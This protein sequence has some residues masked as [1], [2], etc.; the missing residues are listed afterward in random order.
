MPQ[1]KKQL[2]FS[3]KQCLCASWNIKKLWDKSGTAFILCNDCGLVFTNPLPDIE[4][5]K[6]IYKDYLKDFEYDEEY[7]EMRR[8]G[9][10]LLKNRFYKESKLLSVAGKE[11]L[12]LLDV[13]CGLGFFLKELD[14]VFDTC[15][16]EISSFQVGFARQKLGLN[17]FHG[18]L[19]EAK[20][21][22]EYFDVVT[23][24][25][26][27]E[28][29]HNPLE[30][31][32]EIHRILK[33]GGILALSTPNFKG[34]TSLITKDKWHLCDPEE[35]LY[36]FS[37]K[38]I[39]NILQGNGFQITNIFSDN[40]PNIVKCLRKRKIESAQIWEERKAYFH[41]IESNRVLK[42]GKNII[43]YFLNLIK[44]GDNLRVYAKKA[45]ITDTDKVKNVKKILILDNH[46]IG[47][48]VVSIPL[49]KSVRDNFPDAHISILLRSKLEKDVLEPLNLCDSYYY[50]Q[51]V[52]K[53]FADKK[54][55]LHFILKTLLKL[56]NEKFEMVLNT[57]GINMLLAGLLATV[58][59]AKF[60]VGEA[61]GWKGALF[62]VK[63]FP[64]RIHRVERN[65][66]IGRA[67]GLRS[68]VKNPYLV[69][70]K[71]S[72]IF[73]TKIINEKKLNGKKLVGIHVANPIDQYE[74]CWPAEKYAELIDKISVSFPD[75]TIAIFGSS[76]ERIEV[77]KLHINKISNV[78]DFVGRLEINKTIAF[79]KRCDLFVSGDGGLM[80]IASALNVP[81]VSLFGPTDSEVIAPYWNKGII[82][83]SQEDCSPC[84]DN[85]DY[86][87][88]CKK[89]VKCMKSITVE[90]VFDAVNEV[91]ARY[92]IERKA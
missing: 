85:E 6:D 42:Y 61:I 53:S 17:I 29:L 27:I 41:K 89:A 37:P 47:D 69:V 11:K 48:V 28:H 88:G 65:N 57:Q 60:K 25:E 35:H 43:N 13:G 62:N 68:F 54:T 59:G 7:L 90:E 23:M 55:H 26:V 83:K 30:Y 39:K 5:I 72:A 49:L 74:R 9:A 38:S 2:N 76:A 1:K 58:I 21:P 67:I 33:P 40:I 16:I 3:H 66:N 91:L 92:S 84:Y 10:S 63:V 77:E 31:I 86:R 36:Y 50:F 20:F 4:V 18:T 8:K 46:G 73:V 14:D 56:R 82:I 51:R 71:E 52:K 79:I 32:K 87:R 12:H 19:L 64:E 78:L 22:A 44:R 15:G 45:S 81:T 34:L 75:I 70:D 24:W 80:H